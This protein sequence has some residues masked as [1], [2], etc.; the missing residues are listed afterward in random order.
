MDDVRIGIIGLGFIGSKHAENI[1]NNAIPGAV[2]TAVCDKSPGKDIWVK[3][4]L[5]HGVQL[6]ADAN[7]FFASKRFDAVL[8]ATPHLFHPT[9]AIQAFENGYH[10]LCE[11]PAGVYTKEVRL[12]NEAAKASGKA[13]AM[14]YN[15][16]LNPLYKKLKELISCGELGEFRRINWII[17][18]WYRTQ[19]YY[20][21][22]E[23]RATWEGEGG[24]V[25]INQSPHQLDLL[26]WIVG[27]M[28][29]RIRAFCKFG[30]YHNIEVEDDVTAYLEYENGA[31]GVFI[32]T[33]GEA[34]GTNR[35][36][37]TG[38][39][40]KLVVEDDKLSFWRLRESAYEFSKKFVG[41]DFKQPETWKCEIPVE[42]KI[43]AFDWVGI[44][45]NWVDAIRDGK[46]SLI[47]PGEEGINGLIL[48]N[49]M[50]L[51]SWIDNW[52]DLPIN[53]DL[54]LDLFQEK[55]KN[56]KSNQSRKHN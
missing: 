47:A 9:Y 38:D 23:W 51:S 18:D 1:A 36:E 37:I 54:F 22:S 42:G 53:E 6:F 7:D 3:E 17:T 56:S 39:F 49:G 21:S 5:T 33:T 24:G 8:I 46:T 44:I 19:G 26:Q 34:P 14:M 13:F 29:N 30:K 20:N 25:L 48:S 16:R 43:S 27:K 32:T 45:K 40:G 52:V 2:L 35:L 28:P 55:V 12:M 31:T 10:V 4:T 15:Q 11:K 41:R 50:L